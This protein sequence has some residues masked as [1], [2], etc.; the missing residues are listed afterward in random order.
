M[1]WVCCGFKANFEFLKTKSK[2]FQFQLKQELSR[3]CLSEKYHATTGFIPNF[4][5]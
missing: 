4:E 2:P 3:L 1:I 5:L